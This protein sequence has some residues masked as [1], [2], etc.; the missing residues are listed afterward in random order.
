MARAG[1]VLV[2]RLMLLYVVALC[3][4]CMRLMVYGTWWPCAHVKGDDMVPGGAV[5]VLRLMV[6]CL[7]AVYHAEA[8]DMVLGGP[9][10]A[11]AR[12]DAMMVG[13]LVRVL[14]LVIWCLV[15]VCSC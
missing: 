14:R 7:V 6:W 15:A 11:Y 13:G 9:V 5:L 8:D 1:H 3:S 10:Q 4:C 12:G 2:L